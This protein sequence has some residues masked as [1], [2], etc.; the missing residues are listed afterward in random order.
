MSKFKVDVNWVERHGGKLI[1]KAENAKEAVELL[2]ADQNRLLELMID[3]YA[4]ETF[5][6]LGEV[7]VTGS[8]ADE[9]DLITDLTIKNGS[10]GNQEQLRQLGI[11]P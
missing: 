7:T 4:N 8:K 2:K 11:I 6:Y 10:I 3:K 9:G 5:D 1:I